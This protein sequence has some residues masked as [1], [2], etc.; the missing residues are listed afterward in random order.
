VVPVSGWA[1]VA[2]PVADPMAAVEVSVDGSL[3]GLASYGLFRGDIALTWPHAP[4]D[5]GWGYQLDT[6]AFANGGH[7]VRV[8]A[9][10]SQ[11]R[12]A[13]LDTR[14]VTIGN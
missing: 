7:S 10:T 5:V 6:T 9:R 11:G 3:A 12:V 4:A 13:I 14:Q 8:T 1:I 2:D